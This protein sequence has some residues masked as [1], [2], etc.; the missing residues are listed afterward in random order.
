MACPLPPFWG[1]EACTPLTNQYWGDWAAAPVMLT[2]L[3]YGA[4][5]DECASRP[6]CTRF[7]FWPTQPL[8]CRLFASKGATLFSYNGP[9]S[10][11]SE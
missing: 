9:S 7:T 3:S 4:C 10:F 8:P 1:A 6:N 5:C 2:T 11:Q